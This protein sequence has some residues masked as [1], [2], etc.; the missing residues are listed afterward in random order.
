MVVLRIGR[1]A[2]VRGR[3]GERNQLIKEGRKRM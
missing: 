3:R 1:R 2:K